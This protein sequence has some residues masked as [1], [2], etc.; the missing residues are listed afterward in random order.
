V[1]RAGLGH[2]MDQ[3]GHRR[4]STGALVVYIAAVLGLA[5]LD[6]FG[7]PLLGA[8]LGVAHGVFYPAFNAV[9]VAGVGPGERGKVMSLFQAAFQVGMA[10]GGLGFGL[11]ADAAG[12]PV[13]FQTAA[14]GLALAL[15]VL[16]VSGRGARAASA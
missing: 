1:V 7:L 9:V 13:V 15:V 8:C 11:L 10:S 16:V 4:V 12:Y 14:G 5:R 3:W 2:L 6:L